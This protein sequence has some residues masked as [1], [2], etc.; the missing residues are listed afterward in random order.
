MKINFFAACGLWLGVMSAQASCWSLKERAE[1]DGYAELDNVLILSFKDA[2]SC[3]PLAGAM[4]TIGDTAFETD[5]RGYVTLDMDFGEA[6]EA[7]AP[8]KVSLNGYI[9]L[10]TGLIM[11]AGTVLNRRQ[12]L[13][14]ALPVGTYRFVLQWNETP[15]DL[16][17][18]LQ[19]PDFH[20]SYQNMKNAPNRA[21]LDRDALQGYGPETITLDKVSADARYWLWAHNYSGDAGFSGAE[22]L[23]VYGDGRLLRELRLVSTAQRT[24]HLL[25]IHQS[26]VAYLNQPASP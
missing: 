9:T 13:S 4:V 25:D 11:E 2:V 17:L 5:A 19:G 3:K 16:D 24:V 12:L 22:Q 8:L 26:K 18:H 21:R 10:E 1:I 15:K 23:F 20:V 7:S 6:M 14:P